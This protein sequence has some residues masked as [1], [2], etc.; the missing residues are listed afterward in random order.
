MPGY[1]RAAILAALKEGPNKT[2]VGDSGNY[3]KNDDQFEL[4]IFHGTV[5]ADD[6]AKAGVEAEDETPQASAMAVILNDR[7]VKV[8]LNVPR[9]RRIYT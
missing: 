1:D 9:G 3:Q 7:L 6:L 2:V 8:A 4:W 5:D